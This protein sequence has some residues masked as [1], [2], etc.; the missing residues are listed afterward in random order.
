MMVRWSPPGDHDETRC[1]FLSYSH[2]EQSGQ[3]GL[4]V[5]QP[6]LTELNVLLS[7]LQFS[8]V[9]LARS[10]SVSSSST[11]SKWTLQGNVSTTHHWGVDII[12]MG[13]FCSSVLT[14]I[15]SS[16]MK[17]FLTLRDFKTFSLYTFFHSLC[18]YE[19][20]VMYVRRWG[21]VTLCPFQPALIILLINVALGREPIYVP[22]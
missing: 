4:L 19:V 2:A 10:L 21:Y 14:Y 5:P 13:L 1:N 7:I 12:S 8:V 3:S 16:D 15:S 6:L 11:A 18:I 17:R 22:S 9:S 20:V